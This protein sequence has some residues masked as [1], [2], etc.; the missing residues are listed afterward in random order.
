MTVL[1]SLSNRIFA[2]SALLAVACIVAA[3]WSINRTVTVQAERAIERGL[4]DSATLVT[5]YRRLTLA[6]LAQAAHL[7]ADLPKLK[8][9]VA[10]DDPPTLAPLAD[11]YRR[12]LDADVLVIAN[13]RGRVLAEHG[14]AGSEVDGLSG[15]R[16]APWPAGRARVAF[17]PRADGLLLLVSVPIWIDP[18][19]PDLL[20]TLS[21]GRTMDAAFAGQVKGFTDSDIT[22]AWDGAVRAST[23]PPSVASALASSGPDGTTS[24]RVTVAGEQFDVI[25]R[26]IDAD[27]GDPPSVERWP[28]RGP[29]PGVAIVAR[30]RTEQL[31]PLRALHTALALTAVAAVV[32]ATFLSYLVSRSIT[33]PLRALTATMR[34]MAASGDL[35]SWRPE[36]T[37]GR[38]DD[39]DARVLASTFGAMTS[40]LARFQRAA[41]QRERLSTLGRLSTVV[42]HEIRNP[43]MIIKAALRSLRRTDPGP[44]VRAAVADIDEEV[45]RLNQLVNQVLDFARPIRF[46]VGPASLAEVCAD[47]V[48]AAQADGLEVECALRLDPQADEVATDAERLRQ[49]LINVLANA[50]QAVAAAGAAAPASQAPV[51]VTTRV[52]DADSVRVEVRDTGPGLDAATLARVFEPFFTTK[53]TGTG[54]GLAITRNIVEGLGGTVRAESTPGDGATIVMD[55]PRT[56]RQTG[57]P[58]P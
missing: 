25:A 28:G 51:T 1:R 10:L 44:E 58:T 38:W 50:R 17:L 48:R 26:S 6:Q 20:G 55:L 40:S 30:S 12:Q 46:A 54:I 31:R 56:A 42:A 47:A 13:A 19:A 45:S 15:N 5:E 4:A 27:L 37:A 29:S 39:E 3:L 33:Q 34:E 52:L 35:T 7:L 57:Q 14:L 36:S 49:A 41:S 32:A 18:G 11:D 53:P 9:A 43:L 24:R 22:F 23:L 21:V 2:A 8:A 16:E